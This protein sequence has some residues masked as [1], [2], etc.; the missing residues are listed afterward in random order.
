[1][2]TAVTLL[3][4]HLF[5]YKFAF[6]PM[7]G[8]VNLQYVLFWLQSVYGNGNGLLFHCQLSHRTEDVFNTKLVSLCK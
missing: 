8:T 6:F 1:M 7:G 3:S 5:A 4:L 2:V